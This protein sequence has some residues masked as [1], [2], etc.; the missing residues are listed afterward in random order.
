M[1]SA[2]PTDTKGLSQAPKRGGGIGPLLNQHACDGSSLSCFAKRCCTGRQAPSIATRLAKFLAILLCAARPLGLKTK[3]T[4]A[5]FAPTKPLVI[6]DDPHST[7]TCVRRRL[8]KKKT[9][10]FASVCGE[11]RS[12][13]G[14]AAV[15]LEGSLGRRVSP[16]RTT[17]VIRQGSAATCLLLRREGTC[18]FQVGLLFACSCYNLGHPRA[19]TL[20]WRKLCVRSKA[21]VL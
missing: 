13:S 4:S 6:I 5:S 11:V 16:P 18:E 7:P 3:K 2:Q 1:T 15:E 14:A 9:P 12:P 21:G 20:F 8:L 10:S 19:L 17:S